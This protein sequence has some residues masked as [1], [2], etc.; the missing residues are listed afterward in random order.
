MGLN[1]WLS[2][3]GVGDGVAGE[4]E[5]RAVELTWKGAR[6]TEKRNLDHRLRLSV[7]TPTSGSYEVEHECTVP[8]DRVPSVGQVLPVTVSSSDPQ[9][10]VV[11]WDSVESTVARAERLADG[12]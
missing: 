12:R 2:R 10:L 7:T 3:R 4:A 6:Q 1:D 5:V 11:E 8:W 9:R